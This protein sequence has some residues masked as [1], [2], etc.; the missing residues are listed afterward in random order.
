MFP[1]FNT[2]P[3]PPTTRNSGALKPSWCD[4]STH[5]P[6]LNSGL[7]RLASALDDKPLPR[8]GPTHHNQAAGYPGSRAQTRQSQPGAWC[9][10]C[11]PRLVPTAEPWGPAPLCF[12]P[13]AI[14]D[15][16]C[17]GQLD[18]FPPFPRFFILTSSARYPLLRPT[19]VRIFHHC[20][21][22]QSHEAGIHWR[23]APLYDKFLSIAAV[24]CGQ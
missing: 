2:H 5:V 6:G 1:P 24:I 8:L 15:R 23:T 22:P 12:G 7:T 10:Q 18:V 13:N 20:G 11:L 19:F 3:L 17:A 4:P 14:R 9:F 16:R 21:N